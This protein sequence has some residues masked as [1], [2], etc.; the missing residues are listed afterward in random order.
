MKGQINMTS[1]DE[2]DDALMITWP[3]IIRF[4]EL[5][6][7]RLVDVRKYYKKKDGGSAPTR[8]GIALT[9]VQFES[10]ASAFDE[11]HDEIIQWFES[12]ATGKLA[13]RIAVEETR[14]SSSSFAVHIDE[15]SGLEMFKYE[16][17]GDEEKLMMNKKH[18]WVKNI[19]EQSDGDD[20]LL[21]VVAQIL[22]TFSR[23][24]NLLD[25]RN[26][27]IAD[28]VESIVGNWGIFARHLPKGASKIA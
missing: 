11:K 12:K 20:Q 26:E 14:Y 17:V 19:L 25:L 24:V 1:V 3:I 7:N 2:F 10:V 4:S 16:N 18:P 22:Y 9:Q 28:L 23:A 8:K 13:E 6:G 5:E 15:W 27:T 21:M